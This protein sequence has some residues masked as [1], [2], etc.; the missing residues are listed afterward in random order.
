[1]K[2]KTIKVSKDAY[3]HFHN[4]AYVMDITVAE[5]VDHEIKRRELGTHYGTR[6]KNGKKPIIPHVLKKRV[7]KNKVRAKQKKARKKKR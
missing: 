5:A 2:T 3:E 6:P 1:M 4:K 7:A